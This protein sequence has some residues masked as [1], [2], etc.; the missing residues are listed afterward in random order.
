MD[1]NSLRLEI[2][3]KLEKNMR[4]FSQEYELSMKELEERIDLKIIENERLDK[5]QA[6]IILALLFSNLITLLLLLGH[7]TGAV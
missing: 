5:K 1:N 7:L 4:L 6:K 3:Q 2:H